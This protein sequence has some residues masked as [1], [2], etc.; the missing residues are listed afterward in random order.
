MNSAGLL[1]Y[2]S[3]GF[4]TGS[5]SYHSI[6]HLLYINYNINYVK[7]ISAYIESI[8]LKWRITNMFNSI[9]NTFS[10]F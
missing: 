5:F 10:T 3:Q 8:F 7:K 2:E 4:L 6:I 9:H 1:N